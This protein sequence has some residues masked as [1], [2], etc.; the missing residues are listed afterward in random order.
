MAK[1]KENHLMQL[2]M[3]DWNGKRPIFFCELFKKFEW[4]QF[5]YL[6]CLK[7]GKIKYVNN[8][9]NLQ[10]YYLPNEYPVKTKSKGRPKGKIKY[11]D[12][13]EKIEDNF[14]K[15]DIKRYKNLDKIQW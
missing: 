15:K 10:K 12:E 8:L 6:K 5:A 14:A 11:K 13:K 4:H 3:W 1:C 9:K 2:Y 7:C